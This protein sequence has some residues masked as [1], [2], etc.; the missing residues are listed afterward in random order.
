MTDAAGGGWERFEADGGV[1]LL[2][3]GDSLGEMLAQAALGLFALIADPAGVEARDVREVRAH[4][5]SPEGLL[6]AWLNEC[7]YVHEVEGFVARRVEPR[8]GGEP[9][10]LHG[11]LHGEDVDAARHERGLD[12]RSAR[13]RDASVVRAAG[14]LEGRVVLEVA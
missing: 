3:R 5:A 11:I 7:L 8:A 12:V 1:G 2:A 10:R 6:V 13:S 4:A 9:F 14:R